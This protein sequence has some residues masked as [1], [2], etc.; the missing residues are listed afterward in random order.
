FAEPS[1]PLLGD[2]LRIKQVVTN[3][4]NNAIK[5]TDHG[6]ITVRTTTES[7]NNQYLVL[8]VSVTDTGI[9]LTDAE[10]SNL[11][12]AFSQG[13]ASS[14]RKYGGTGLGLVI[15]KHLVQQ[16]CGDVGFHS[17]YQT[18]STFWF[19]LQLA[20]NQNAPQSLSESTLARRRILVF[21]SNALVRLSLR[22]SL[23]SSQLLVEEV[24]SL[25]AIFSHLDPER[26]DAK[27]ID[28]VILGRAQ[29]HLSASEI[30]DLVH[31]IEDQYHR[32]CIV[33][34]TTHERYLLQSKLNLTP[35][36]ILSKPVP[37]PKL[38]AALE[39]ALLENAL[40]A[41]TQ[42][43]EH[44]SFLH[45]HTDEL[46]TSETQK[47]HA[48]CVDDNPSNLTLIR[49]LL[50]DIGV[51]VTTCDNGVKALEAIGKTT[52]DIIFMD[53]QMPRMDGVETTR[54]IRALE[55]E[56]QTPIVALTAHALPSE[57]QGLFKA[58]MNEYI[59][60]P[61]QETQ[62]IHILKKHTHYQPV[63]NTP[64]T[65]TR[66]KPATNTANL[67]PIRVTPQIKTHQHSAPSSAP[68]HTRDAYR[69]SSNAAGTST[70]SDRKPVFK[71]RKEAVPTLRHPER[72][73]TPV[74][75]P[76]EHLRL[77]NHKEDLAE[78]LLSILIR[79][80]GPT[81]QALQSAWENEDYAALLEHTHKLHG[82]THY[83]GVPA[84]RQ[85]LYQLETLIKQRNISQ[86]P[87]ALRHALDQ[88]GRLRTALTRREPDPVS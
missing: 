75:D 1:T 10:Q 7:A 39:H 67:L 59:T 23:E 48:L 86:L 46:E 28:A 82:A 11:F 81:Q 22:N 88:I 83:C 68:S 8:K 31:L 63:S 34:C 14:A 5:F 35:S 38:Y 12:K 80:L 79:S 42:D 58:G 33:L 72:T 70:D 57:K 41:P 27:P 15:C 54:K 50:E 37:Q 30:S 24:D 44:S 76:A 2:P 36:Q 16:M 32:K 6:C 9:G 87:N 77:S 13:D 47:V 45:Q 17:E 25:N 60:K 26:H 18:G 73:Q 66:E 51:R 40:L 49:A 65:S 52:F 56:D 55:S 85:A 61:M 71:R 3:L 29:E 64:P 62:L 19:T 69:T 53:I 84:L 21:D 20:I 43:V 78:Q 74:F 4:V